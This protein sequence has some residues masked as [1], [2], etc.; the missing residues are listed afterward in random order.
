MTE[1][2]RIRPPSPPDR[3]VGA[4][5][6][7]WEGREASGAELW[8]NGPCAFLWQERKWPCASR[9]SALD[10]R[11]ILAST[12]AICNNT[13]IQSVARQN[14]TPTLASR[15]TGRGSA[16]RRIFSSISDGEPMSDDVFGYSLYP[17]CSCSGR[18]ETIYIYMGRAIFHPRPRARRESRCNKYI[19]MRRS[20]ASHKTS[21]DSVSFGL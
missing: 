2:T 3:F 15:D 16:Q 1:E 17:A 10:T 20:K 4:S 6:N 5:A 7:Y 8:E 9:R 18:R 21:S 14:T 11:Y 13:T 19:M 12:C